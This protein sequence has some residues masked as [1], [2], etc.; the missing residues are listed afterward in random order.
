MKTILYRPV[1][2]T[3]LGNRLRGLTL[4]YAVAIVTGRRLAVDDYLITEYFHPPLGMDWDAKPLNHGAEGESWRIVIQHLSPENWNEEEYQSYLTQDLNTVFPETVIEIVQGASFVDALRTNPH[5]QDL[6]KTMGMD[7]NDPLQWIGG[8][9]ERLLARPKKRLL[10][11]ADQLKKKLHW[12]SAPGPRIAVQY[13][14]FYDIGSPHLAAVTDFMD[15]IDH[16]LPRGGPSPWFFVTT[17]DVSATAQIQ[18]TLSKR[19]EV[20]TSGVQRIVHTGYSYAG[21]TEIV[22]KIFRKLWPQLKPHRFDLWRIV[23]EALRPRHQTQVLAEWYVLG[24]CDALYST[25]TTFAEFAAARNANVAALIRFD[26]DSRQT[27][28]LKQATPRSGQLK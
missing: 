16:H 5:Y 1:D 22:F 26:P 19:G 14:T 21:W 25:F 23:P 7:P 24:D 6:W 13:R 27:T 4:C 12:N 20:H 11:A 18:A 15:A 17:D 2:Q 10:K 3:G 28:V 9:V 8:L